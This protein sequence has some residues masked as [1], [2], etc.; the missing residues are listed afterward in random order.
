MVKQVLIVRKDLK[1]KPGKLAS[2]VAHAAMSIFFKELLHGENLEIPYRTIENNEIK[3]SHSYYDRIGFSEF[4]I[5]PSIPYFKE[6]IEGRFKKIVVFVNS[7]EEL[8]AIYDKAQGAGIH[9]SLIRDAGLTEFDGVPTYTAVGIGPWDS[10]EI[11]EIT[12]HLK[13]L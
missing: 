6:Y 9:S 12:G 8:H 5:L 4:Y 10:K 1:M 13:L 11:D 2:Q 3:P 7:E